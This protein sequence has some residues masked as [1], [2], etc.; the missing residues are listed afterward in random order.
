VATTGFQGAAAA[1]VAFLVCFGVACSGPSPPPSAPTAGEQLDSVSTSNAPLSEIYENMRRTEW[2]SVQRDR[3]KASLVGKKVEWT[4]YI[5]RVTAEDQGQW[6]EVRI[7]SQDDYSESPGFTGRRRR[8]SSKYGVSVILRVPKEFAERVTHATRGQHVCF[9]GILS[10][11]SSG[12][13]GLDAVYLSPA[14][15]VD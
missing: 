2:T 9:E 11:V 8:M 6:Y 10:E 15:I 1:A 14:R 4:G 13:R 12:G 7:S 5:D 3:Y